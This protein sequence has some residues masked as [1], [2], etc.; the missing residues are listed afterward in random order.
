MWTMPR[1]TTWRAGAVACFVGA[2]GLLFGSGLP[3]ITVLQPDTPAPQFEL[4]TLARETIAL[5]DLQG[6]PVVINFWATWCVPC[7]IEMPALQ[8]LHERNPNMSVLAIN[9]NED[10]R[11]I[12]EWV[13]N[14]GLTFDILIDDNEQVAHLYGLQGP[15][16]T[17]VVSEEGTIRRVFYGPVAA[18]ELESV[19]R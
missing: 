16:A 8:A 11:V 3:A 1:K 14:F 13:A 4:P 15:P 17:F 12:R 5:D 9:L 6:Q 7:R 18:S 2:A 19:L 10:E